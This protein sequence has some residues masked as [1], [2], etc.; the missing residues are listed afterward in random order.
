MLIEC[1]NQNIELPDGSSAKDLAEKLNLRGPDQ[2]IAANINGI[3]KD[4]D[5]PLQDGDKVILWNFEDPEGKEVFWHSSAH[6]LAQAI[7]RLWQM[8]NQ[9]LVPRSMMDSIMILPI[10]N[11]PM[12]TSNKSRRK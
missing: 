9:R 1:Q 5:T 2:A 10:C 6:V 11:S 8:Q 3:T 7:L 4:L 12:P